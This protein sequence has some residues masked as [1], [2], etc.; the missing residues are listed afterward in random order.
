MASGGQIQ[1]LGALLT[2]VSLFEV[3]D[4]QRNYA[5]EESNVDDLHQDI[6]NAVD[7]DHPHFI[8]STILMKKPS[9]GENREYLIVDGQQR[10]TT[11]FMYLSV[12]RDRV[13]ALDET[14]LPAQGGGNPVDVLSK[15]Q[16]VLFSNE[17]TG[18]QRFHSNPLNRTMFADQ[19]VS[20]PSPNRKPLPQRHFNFSLALRKAYRRVEKKID[21][22]ITTLPA[23]KDALRFLYDLL[24]AIRSKLQIL[25]I[26]TD[27]FNESLDIF[28][29]LNSRGMALGPSDLVK[30]EIFKNITHNEP[31]T[32]TEKISAGLT[33]E[34]KKLS[35]QLEDLDIDQFLRHFLVSTRP[36]PT[37]GKH[38][39]ATYQEV[40]KED[41]SGE[42]KTASKKLL[43]NLI[44][45]SELYASCAQATY[46]GDSKVNAYLRVMSN[47]QDSYRVFL[48]P[49]IDSN[50]K[51]TKSERQEL[52]RIAELVALRWVLSGGN[53]QELEDKFQAASLLLRGADPVIDDIKD[54]LK[55]NLPTDQKMKA[56]FFDA[57]NSPNLVRVV[58]HRINGVLAD[59]SGLIPYDSKNIHV[60][61]IAP[62]SSTSHWLKE[63]F[64]DYTDGNLEAE[65][66][67]LVEQWGNKTIL[68]KHIN[69]K[70]A[71]KPFAQKRDGSPEESWPGYVNSVLVTTKDL[72]NVSTWERNT[73]RHRNKWL[74]ETFCQIWSMEPQHS[75]VLN[76]SEWLS[77][78]T[79]AGEPDQP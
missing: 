31:D 3:P 26:Y 14:R 9:S 6:L 50:V 13:A 15:L 40:I 46:A 47:V 8:G 11:L 16:E 75:H 10:L 27:S 62:A 48:M 57:I 79:S 33:S 36:G 66:E 70:V 59:E 73:I 65:Y 24:N 54:E 34:W 41:D 51:I 19:V 12:I 2:E 68:D 4:F 61:H 23:G 44:D 76:F 67:S 37:T 45:Q 32:E 53:A 20:F 5:W 77:L 56:Q 63:L 43:A 29:T 28:M 7:D 74:G 25:A 71:Q 58:L 69:Q 39:Y 22:S 55:K 21:E 49:V 64:P 72:S 78:Q 38:V 52:A 17:E 60:E 18:V 1:T 42:A 30:S 35:D